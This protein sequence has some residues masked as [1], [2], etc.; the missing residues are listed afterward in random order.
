MSS[1]D[2]RYQKN[3]E[4]RDHH[5]HSIENVW[6]YPRPPSL[7]KVSWRYV[8]ETIAVTKYLHCADILPLLCLHWYRV[9]VVFGGVVIADTLDGWR[10]LET[11]CVAAF[12]RPV[13]LLFVPNMR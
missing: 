10:I 7:E 1:D 13:R 2:D 12:H 4:S 9:R 8:I 3:S 6:E 11:S 5:R